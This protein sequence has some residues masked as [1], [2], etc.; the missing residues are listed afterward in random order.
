MLRRAMKKSGK[1]FKDTL[2]AALQVGLTSV[3]GR[4]KA[5]M[6][7]TPTFP[8]GMISGRSFDR[9]LALADAMEDEAIIAKRELNK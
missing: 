2:N 3:L 4:D 5:P 9:A 7:S 6:V 8:M 1:S